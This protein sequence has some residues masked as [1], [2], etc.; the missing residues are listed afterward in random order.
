M[1]G[2]LSADVRLNACMC[3]KVAKALMVRVG[4]ASE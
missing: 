1:S 4:C 3:M 2:R